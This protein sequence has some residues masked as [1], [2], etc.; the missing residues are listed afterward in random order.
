MNEPSPSCCPPTADSAPPTGALLDPDHRSKVDRRLARLE[1]Q[2]RGVR[3]M[4]EE[5][6]WCLDVLAQIEAVQE[7]L[8]A[9]S[10]ELLSGH[11][12]HCVA[13]AA[14]SGSP[15]ALALRL[16]EVDTLLRRKRS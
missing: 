2:V 10:A 12:R 4:V 1:G 14:R 11:L 13:D 8:R 16:D 15:E 5:G 6:R 3:R 7:G 9:V